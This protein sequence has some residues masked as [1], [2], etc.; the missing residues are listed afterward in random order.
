MDTP[1]AVLVSAVT[2]LVVAYLTIR[3]EQKRLYAEFKTERS[4]EAALKEF[5]GL[6]RY[7]YRSFPMIQHHIG[8]FDE[9]ELRQHL[10]RAGA[11][12]FA[13]ADGT[14]M[15]ALLHRVK[16]EFRKGQW[17][18]KEAPDRPPN[19]SLFPCAFSDSSNK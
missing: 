6:P 18:L 2:A 12:R 1:F 19:E 3:V 9:N 17:K 5:L 15:W 11:V 13:A 10:V 8:G 4:V 7:P 14:E 16:V